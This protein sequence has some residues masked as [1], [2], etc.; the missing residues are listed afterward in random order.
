MRFRLDGE[1]DVET[2]SRWINGHFE[3]HPILPGNIFIDVLATFQVQDGE[4][5]APAARIDIFSW[6]ELIMESV[7]SLEVIITMRRRGR[8]SEQRRS[9]V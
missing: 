5:P 6:K 4:K 7:K 3:D 2:K 8:M 1:P 9:S